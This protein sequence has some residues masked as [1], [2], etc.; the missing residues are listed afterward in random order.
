MSHSRND[1]IERC[2]RR[3]PLKAEQAQR[4]IISWS[5]PL[6]LVLFV[7]CRITSTRA[8]RG[9]SISFIYFFFWSPQNEKVSLSLSVFFVF[10]ARCRGVERTT[11][12]RH[13][14]SLVALQAQMMPGFHGD[15]GAKRSRRPVC[16]AFPSFCLP[17]RLGFGQA[18]LVGC[19]ATD[20][21]RLAHNRQAGGFLQCL[22]AALELLQGVFAFLPTEMGR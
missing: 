9:F 6:K 22:C 18:R 16:T 2:E 3:R 1:A 14:C 4:Q 17:R 8:C 20:Q 13:R 7:S 11:L 15:G 10:L 19:G 12:H 5:A 21:Y